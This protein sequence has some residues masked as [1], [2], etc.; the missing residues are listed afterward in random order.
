MNPPPPWK[1]R[2][3]FVWQLRFLAL[4]A[5]VTLMVWVP[6]TP[7]PTSIANPCASRGTPLALA[8]SRPP[9]L[10]FP[11]IPKT[12]GTTVHKLL[13][14][15][16]NR[17]NGVACWYKHVGDK[18]GMETYDGWGEVNARDGVAGTTLSA[19]E[20]GD[21]MLKRRM[22][23]QGGCRSLHGYVTWETGEVVEKGV[24]SIVLVR[25]P[26]ARFVSMY[27]Y[28]RATM[29]EHAGWEAWLT[30][31]ESLAGEFSNSSS[32]VHRGF[33]DESGRWGGGGGDELAF[34]FYGALY[35]LSGVVPRFEGV[36]DPYHF[37]WGNGEEMKERAKEHVCR[38]HVV[39]VQE[40]MREFWRAFFGRVGKWVEWSEDER[41][42][43]EGVEENRTPGRV[44]RNVD[45][46]LPERI[47]EEL[48]R[49]LKDEKEV[50]QFVREVAR[51]RRA[52]RELGAK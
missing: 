5:I 22:L 52:M 44:S 3:I 42:V 13:R 32:I 35:Q 24:L 50:V 21:A 9:T 30:S 40:D 18:R 12:A 51:Y 27:E 4:V 29:G 46:H 48:E 14:E 25:E 47:R 41:R 49:R 1:R 34:G 19:I 37:G 8:A 6:H 33:V 16:S 36:G 2:P 31:R 28:G 7:V 43:M 39:G 23:I 26:L 45:D 20:A 10:F 38:S 15:Y 11:H 17:T